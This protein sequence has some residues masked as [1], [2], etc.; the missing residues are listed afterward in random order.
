MSAW[1]AKSREPYKRPGARL[2]ELQD[3]AGCGTIPATWGDQRSTRLE[4]WRT[5]IEEP[6]ITQ[7]DTH[8][9][10]PISL[11]EQLRRDEPPAS[12]E[13]TNPHRVSALEEQLRREEPPVA[14]EDTNPHRVSA[15]DEQL[16]RD[17]PPI[18]ADDTSPSRAFRP[19]WAD[20]LSQAATSRAGRGQRVLALMMLAAALALTLA[21][22]W[23]WLDAEENS[24]PPPLQGSASNAPVA[25]AST[26]SPTKTAVP[27]SPKPAD[28]QTVPVAAA[29]I[30]PVTYPTAAA[31]EIAVALLT[32]APLVH[33][34][35]GIQR[36]NEPFTILPAQTR[37][38]VIQ[39]TVQQGDSLENIAAKFGLE[40]FY[41]IIWANSSSKYSPLRP[42][43]TL[44]IV[45]E[46][47]V[48]YEVTENI[49]IGALADKYGVDPYALIDSDYNNLYGSSP[50][51]LLVRGM[52]GIV[53]PGG[54]GEV[55]NL[56]AANTSDGGQS[57]GGVVSGSYSLW[58]CSATVSGGTLPVNRPLSNYKWMQ[59]F[60]PG[61]HTG[62]DLSGNTGD[63][64]YAAGGGTV[65]YAGW[66]TY[67][68]GN[69]VVIAHG[70]AFSLYAHL[71]SINVSCGQNVGAGDV[72][73]T[74][75]STG[76][77]SGSHLHF[78]VRDA[79]FNARNPQDY[80]SF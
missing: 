38:N 70:A 76:N 21:A 48:Y 40:D 74:L 15:L 9:E 8:P 78:E 13:D 7:N 2:A 53:I 58:G 61:G 59:G 20:D 47:G 18:A 17:E 55:V 12:D 52:G 24:E 14:D 34:I 31:D 36:V 67:G 16:R 50:D 57:S 41:S 80:V 27:S 51:T 22:T 79:D 23:L 72:I 32:P 26:P 66:N 6:R 3:Q 71:N 10:K 35:T 29:R 11:D 46:D 64:V 77:S 39:Y 25:A 44:N 62:V 45:P 73:G 1:P 5:M 28:D 4:H 63:P 37:S 19:S 56:L 30:D 33:E 43:V 69:V 54:K 65:V 42:G 49:T 60:V 75:G 68:Y